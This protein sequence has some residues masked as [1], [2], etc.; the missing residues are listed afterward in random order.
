MTIKQ[1]V[2]KMRHGMNELDHRILSLL[3]QQRERPERDWNPDLCD[4]GAVLHQ[5][6]H[7]AN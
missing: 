5:L 2:F 4:A 7:Q 1:F 3:K 6:S